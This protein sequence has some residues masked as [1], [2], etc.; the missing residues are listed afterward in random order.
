MPKFA[1]LGD[2]PR[3][4]HTLGLLNPG[5]SVTATENPD[6]IWFAPAKPDKPAPGNDTAPTMKEQ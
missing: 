2:E 1:Y 5:D 6:P 3:A 4:F